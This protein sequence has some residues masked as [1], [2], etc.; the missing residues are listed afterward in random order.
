MRDQFKKPSVRLVTP[1]GVRMRRLTVF[2][3][4][5]YSHTT[6]LELSKGALNASLS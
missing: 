2:A 4:S 6:F 3:N 5:C 1:H